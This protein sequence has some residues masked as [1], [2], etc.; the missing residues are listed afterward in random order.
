MT[1]RVREYI[2]SL[3]DEELRVFQSFVATD[4]TS[5]TERA[6]Y[7][8]E[9]A[10]ECA[11]REHFASSQPVT[12]ARQAPAKPSEPIPITIFGKRGQPP[13]P[14]RPPEDEPRIGGIHGPGCTRALRDAGECPCSWEWRR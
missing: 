1:N 11:A 4:V 5:V 2:A 9:L 3:S 14:E 8:I 10:E 12:P 7:A 6:T 13:R